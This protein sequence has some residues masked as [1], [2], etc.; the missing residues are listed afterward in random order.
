MLCRGEGD[1]AADNREGTEPISFPLTCEAGLLSLDPI[2]F[3]IFI[4]QKDL[5]RKLSYN[6]TPGYLHILKNLLLHLYIFIISF[7]SENIFK[8]IS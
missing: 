8:S 5:E 2:A 4:K 3:W 6:T 7:S 1:T